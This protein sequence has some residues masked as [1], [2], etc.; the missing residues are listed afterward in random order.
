MKFFKG[1]LLS[2]HPGSFLSFLRRTAR[3]GS[4]IFHGGCDLY[5][6]YGRVVILLCFL[7]NYDNL[8][9]PQGKRSYLIKGWLVIGIFKAG[10][11]LGMSVALETSKKSIKIHY[12]YDAKPLTK[13]YNCY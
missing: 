3:K 11:V 6:N 1:I 7:C 9:L 12:E 5:G 10:S 2:G 13:S 4:I 8:K